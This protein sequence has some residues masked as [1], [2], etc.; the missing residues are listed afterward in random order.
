VPRYC[1]YSVR[2]SFDR[3]LLALVSLIHT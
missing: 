2:A 3:G 1:K